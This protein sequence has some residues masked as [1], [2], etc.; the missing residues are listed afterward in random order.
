M[1][2]YIVEFIIANE[3]SAEN[4]QI[5]SDTKE[6]GVLVDRPNMAASDRATA[7]KGHI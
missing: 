6:I 3:N 2:D 7:G 4:S 1:R 5:R